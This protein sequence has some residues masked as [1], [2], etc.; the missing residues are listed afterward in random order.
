MQYAHEHNDK[1]KPNTLLQPTHLNINQFKNISGF[2][3]PMGLK[4]TVLIRIFA[5]SLATGTGVSEVAAVH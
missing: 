4:T 5:T 2:Q 1:L 3:P